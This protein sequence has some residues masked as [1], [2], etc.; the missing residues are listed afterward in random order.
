[1]DIET[2]FWS[3]VDRSGECWNWLAACF[4]AGYGCFSVGGKSQGSHRISWELRNGAIPLDMQ[5]LHRCDN[6]K[7]VRPG[8]LFLGTNA[9]NMADKIGKGRQAFTRGESHG[10]CRLTK[11]KV[12]LIRSRY[13]SGETTQR[14][15]AAEFGIAQQHV[16][17]IVNGIFW[18]QDTASK[19]RSTLRLSV[20]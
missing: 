6:R 7:C 5:V 8:H 1:M 10:M 20:Q 9:D 16:S 4:S 14:A 15:I 11:S 19:K 13:A 3:K 12:R 18:R 2:R 17:A